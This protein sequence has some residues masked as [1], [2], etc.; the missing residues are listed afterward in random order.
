MTETEKKLLQAQHRSE[1]AQARNRVKKR[2][3][4]TR[5]LIQEG[6]IWKRCCRRC[7]RWSCLRW[8]GI[9]HG[10]WEK[11]SKFQMGGLR[12]TGGLPLFSPEGRTYSPPRRGGG[13][14]CGNRAL[15]E[16]NAAA[17]AA[18]RQCHSTC[19]C[20]C[21]R[22]RRSQLF[23]FW[24]QSAPCPHK[25]ATGSFACGYDPKLDF[26]AFSLLRKRNRKRKN[27]V[28]KIWRF[29]I[30]K[31]RWSAGAQDAPLWPLLPI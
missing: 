18:S 8:R 1:E 15:C 16:A 23:P 14:S 13:I 6:A 9:F 4:R 22:L 5:R 19:K 25:P 21:H 27:E 7:G 11:K 10:S 2:K 26:G 31:R 28:N 12:E 20:C 30:W 24:K 17:A 3:A 29:I